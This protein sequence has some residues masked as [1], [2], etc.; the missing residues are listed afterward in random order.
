[1]CVYSSSLQ[2]RKLSKEEK[3]VFLLAW[4]LPSFFFGRL[5]DLKLRE[6]GKVRPVFRTLNTFPNLKCVPASFPLGVRMYF[7]FFLMEECPGSA[8]RS[9]PRS[10]L[11]EPKG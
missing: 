8:L 1:M 6:C 9:M 4:L 7:S 2:L 5:K 11:R 3:T 10:R